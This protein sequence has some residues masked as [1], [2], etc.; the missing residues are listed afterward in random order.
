MTENKT[1][2]SKRPP[3]KERPFEKILV[4]NRGEIAI[5]IIRALRQMGIG[6]VAVFSEADRTA[7]HVALADEAVAI[8]PA[9]S[10]ASYLRIDRIIEAAKK[11]GCEAVHPGYGFLAENPEFSQGLKDEGIVFI[12]PPADSIRAMG[13]KVQARRLSEKA[14]VSPI[15]GTTD[16]PGID[17]PADQI[18]DELGYP[19]LIK[20]AAGGG[21]KGMRVVKSQ[22]ELRKA[23]DEA[24][25]EAKSSFG[26]GRLFVEKYV[27]KPRHIEVQV[28]ADTMGNVIHLGERECSVQRRHQKV[29]EES[30]SVIVDDE[31]R[32]ELGESAV[33]VAAAAGYTNAGTVEFVAD[34]KGSFFFLEMNTRLQVEHPVTEMITGLDLVKEQV[35]VAAGEPLSLTQEEVSFKGSAIECRIYAEDPERNFAPSLGTISALRLPEGPGVRNDFA[36]YEG[37]TI[38][39][40]YDPLIGKLIV[41]G[42]DRYEAIRR[43][44]AALSEFVLEGVRTT[45]GFHKW[46]MENEHFISGDYD[47]HFIENHFRGVREGEEDEAELAIALAAAIKFE[48]DTK[49]RVAPAQGPASRWKLLGRRA[50]LRGGS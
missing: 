3:G 29:V 25:A 35:M 31:T 46:V 33:R 13:D 50:M 28:M 17:R 26:D 48:E 6:S 49:P 12:G 27:Q 36:I 38:P 30:P 9:E 2:T 23:V 16:D 24:R 32:K 18:A 47:T 19:V 15:P 40:Y 45:I 1:K 7:L 42:V 37:Y 14:G 4:A 11:M 21:G 10:G 8:G 44:Y 39:I 43:T 5:R 20:A 22:S 34:G 41:W